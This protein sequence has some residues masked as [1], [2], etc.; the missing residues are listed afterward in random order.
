MTAFASLDVWLLLDAALAIAAA[1]LLVLPLGWE[2]KTHGAANVG[3]RTLPLVSVG[4]CGYLLLGRYLLERD[5]FDADGTARALRAVMTGIGFIGGGAILKHASSTKGVQGL[6]TATSVWTTGAI[7]A[8]V[9]HGYYSIAL[10]LSLASLLIIQVSGSLAGR[11][12]AARA[13]G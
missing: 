11:A 10:A 8:S 13:D 2:R 6:T 3:L 4:T 7:A 5:V 1:Y 12:R 9:A